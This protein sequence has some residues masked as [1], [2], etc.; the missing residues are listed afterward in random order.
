MR[1]LF[2]FNVFFSSVKVDSLGNA[3]SLQRNFNQITETA[4][5]S[6]SKGLSYLLTGELH[7]S[8]IF[9]S[10]LHLLSFIFNIFFPSINMF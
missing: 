8:V 3:Q 7:V 6:I 2:V 5:T 1:K 10:Y 4:N 9:F